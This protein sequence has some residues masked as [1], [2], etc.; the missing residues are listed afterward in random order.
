MKILAVTKGSV[1]D[2]LGIRAGEELV[3]FDGFPV[4][5]VLDYDYYNSCENFTMRVRSKD[6]DTEYEIEKYDDEDL[7]LEL[8]R[9]IP[10][11]QCRNRCIFCFV[12]QLPKQD[13]RATL[14]VKDDDYRHSFIFGNYVTLTNVSSR[15]LDRILR[16]HLSP[17]YVSIH[18]SDP[19]LR[20]KMLGI[21][22]QSNV[23][24]LMDQ[25]RRLH[26]GGIC[27]H[28]QV[29]YCPGVNDDVDETIRDVSPYTQSLAIVPVGLTR[30][31][32]PALRR[33]DK[34]SAAR[35]LDVVE[36]W[37]KKLL[38]ERGTRYVF[39]ADELYLKA[40]RECPPYETYED[41][42]QIENGIGLV[43]AFRHDFA[44]AMARY[45]KGNV[46][47]A[48]V[49]TGVS[50]Y[51]LIRE[52]AAAVERKFGG[53]IYVYEVPNDFFGESVTVAGL[54][55]GKDIANY[56]HGKPLGSR[57]LLPRVMLREGGDVFLDGCT[58]K[59]LSDELGVRVQPIASDGESFVKEL[60]GV[61][62]DA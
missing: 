2:E 11:R 46:G 40:G 58:P 53:R 37:Q 62:E 16:L 20:R 8:N 52:C 25:L 22:G 45:E 12:D 13:L 30:D 41:F 24:D 39:A 27:V 1:A 57:L 23:P 5:D 49:V 15:E 36:K 50:A 51:P 43:A 21:E 17:L 61:K 28:G 10:V 6:A 14:R 60:I 44:D 31:A 19:A 29:V 56:L 4:I 33:V 18:T 38:A 59:K 54:L 9:D 35:V 32:N 42:A 3:S 47:E 55:V 7:G 34:E 26:E 48:S